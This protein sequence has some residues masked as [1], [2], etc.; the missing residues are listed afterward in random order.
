[1]PTPVLPGRPEPPGAT[2]DAGGTNFVLWS[3]VATR[4]ELCLFDEAGVET[5]IDLPTSTDSRWHGYVPGVGPGQRYGYRV[6]GPYDTRNGH[7]CNPAKLLLDPY[8]QAVDG[9]VTWHDALFG[10]PVIA[11]PAAASGDATD[12][13]DSAPAQARSV[14]VDDG[15]FDWGDDVRPR[16]PWTDSVVYEVHVKGFTAA[17]PGVPEELRGTYAGFGHPAAVQH[18]LDLGVTAVE[19][20]PIQF[21]VSER[22]VEERGQVNYWGYNP[23]GWFAPH[24]AYAHAT[25]PQG[26]VDE[27]KGMVQALHAAGIEVLLDVVYNHTAEGNHMGP[28]LSLRGIDQHEYYRLGTDDRRHL[29]NYS[30]TGNTVD[31]RTPQSVRLIMDSLRHLVTEWHVDGFRFDLATTLARGANGFEAW[32]PLL[33][34]ISQDPVLSGTKLIA[35]PWDVGPDGYQLGNFPPPWS[36]WNARFRDT[37]RDYWRGVDESLPELAARLAGSQDLFDHSRREPIASVN[38]LTAHDGYTLRDL[39]TYQEKHNEANGYANTDGHDDNRSWNHGVEG[40]TD[41]PA[42]VGLRRRQQRNL[43]AT[44]LLSQGVPML[45]GGDEL[46]RTQGGNNNAFVLDDATTWFDW[47]RVDEELLAYTRGLIDF[48]QSHPAFRRQA[49]LRGRF[50]DGADDFDMIWLTD[51]GVEMQERDWHRGATRTI[52]AVLNGGTTQRLAANGSPVRDGTFLLLCNADDRARTFTLPTTLG[53]QWRSVLDTADGLPPSDDR[54]VVREAGA[55]IELID[56]SL[57]L[58]RRVD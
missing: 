48:R 40:E 36:E 28:T 21:F 8:A 43:L 10:W 34:A 7:R 37:I 39:V 38:L 51:G 22:D 41:D 15:A 31:C 14:V 47:A 42:I 45:L 44:L 20:L 6:H 35:E 16:T 53:E 5:R 19:L 30:G 58:L 46:G 27:V 25:D 23:V 13:R 56:R 18:L 55:E 1:M 3:S 57:V 50:D 52:Q 33:T 29:A 49:W 32:A 11:G 9:E 12:T 4:V 2:P 26:V 17:H 24:P 54:D